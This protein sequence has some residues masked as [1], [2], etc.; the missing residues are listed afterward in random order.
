MVKGSK[1]SLSTF[2]LRKELSSPKHHHYLMLLDYQQRYNN[3]PAASYTA[4]T[5]I[6]QVSTPLMA[7]LNR[8]QSTNSGARFKDHVHHNWYIMLSHSKHPNKRSRHTQ[9]LFPEKT[10]L[11]AQYHRI[12][13][14]QGVVGCSCF[15]AVFRQIIYCGNIVFSHLIDSSTEKSTNNFEN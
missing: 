8:T 2:Q 7:W 13:C 1:V 3:I 11:E 15:T 10:S 14:F 6:E 12:H 5:P 9:P 4:C